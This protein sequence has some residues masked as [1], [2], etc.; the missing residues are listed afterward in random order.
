MILQ[1]LFEASTF[2][3]RSTSQMTYGFEFEVMINDDS[4]DYFDDVFEK[5][6]EKYP[7]DEFIRENIIYFD[8]SDSTPRYGFVTKEDIAEYNSQKNPQEAKLVKEILNL[9]DKNY[10]L[11]LLKYLRNVRNNIKIDNVSDFDNYLNNEY[12]IDFND[13]K[14]SNNLDEKILEN[15]NYFLYVPDYINEKEI[16]SYFYDKNNN[17]INKKNID[18]S[19]I[20]EI[21]EDSDDILNEFEEDYRSY[22]SDMTYKELNKNN[23][24]LKN[25]KKLLEKNNIRNVKV[26]L[27]ETL[28]EHG[29]EIITGKIFGIDEAISQYNKITK[30][31][32]SE[33]NLYTNRDTGL[34]INIGTWEDIYKIDLVKLL[35]FSNETQILKS[36][37]RKD[38]FFTKS[39]VQNLVYNLQK[40]KNLKNYNKIIR[41]MNTYLLETSMHTSFMDFN[42]L[43]HSG[44]IEIRGFGNRNYEYKS[45]YIIKMIQYLSRVMEI[46]SDPYEAKQQYI[47]KLYKI[48]DIETN[49]SGEK[50]ISNNSLLSNDEINKILKFFPKINKNDYKKGLLNNNKEKILYDFI[51][52]LTD[53][54]KELKNTD[55]RILYKLLINMD[56]TKEYYEDNLKGESEKIDNLFQNYILKGK[57]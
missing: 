18:I 14:K 5:L 20:K 13:F 57:L 26:D 8:F 16:N 22:I 45:E 48:F 3:K 56:I 49:L 39:L 24:N 36:M 38:N 15:M 17:I 21:F 19:K 10:Q 23:I 31:I 30:F 29:V 28:G 1:E 25:M 27:D 47:K 55:I 41:E 50:E 43:K 42:K 46:A 51:P 52:N 44:Y 9:S 4:D 12:S 7:F 40:E 33:E 53:Y 37:E 2:R 6:E 34:H 32:Q 54:D 35:V 11:Y